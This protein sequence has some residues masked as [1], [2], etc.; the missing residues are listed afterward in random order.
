MSATDVSRLLWSRP[1]GADVYRGR[2]ASAQVRPAIPHALMDRSSSARDPRL[3]ALHK[4][5]DELKNLPLNWDGGGS[6][7]PNHAGI[8][9]ARQ[10]VED[11]FQ[12]T[13][14]AGMG[15]S[16]ERPEAVWHPPHISANEDGDTVLEWW[17]GD[18]KLTVYLGPEEVSYIRSW[19]SNV[20]DD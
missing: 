11:L 9:K 14:T 6:A 5:L 20:V 10:F 3:Y 15:N 17:N 4:R 8:A 16:L 2:T 7:A 19:G 18:R 13:T 12:Q 1:Y